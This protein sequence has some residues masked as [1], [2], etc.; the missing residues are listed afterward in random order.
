MS[1]RQLRRRYRDLLRSLD[2]QPPLDVAELCR[3]LGEVRG[4]PIELVAHAIPEPGPFGAWITSPRAEY[5]FYQKN[6]SRL[7]QDHI[8]LHELGHI[9]AGHPGT[10]HDDSLVAEFS[11]DA[12]EAGLRA[13]YPDIPLDAVRLASRRSEY[14]SEQEHEA[15]TVATIILDWASMLDATASRSSQGWARGMDTALGDRLGWL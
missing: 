3:R 2:V 5:I 1:E 7:H 6:T 8:I 9:L 10:E 15:E 4:K 11:S 14:D 12:D 13:A